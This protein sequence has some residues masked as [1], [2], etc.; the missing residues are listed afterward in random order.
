M[1]IYFLIFTQF[2]IHQSQSRHFYFSFFTVFIPRFF[3]YRTL[4]YL[5]KIKSIIQKKTILH[6]T[7]RKIARNS[8]TYYY[9][10]NKFHTRCK[11]CQQ[12]QS[13]TDIS[14]VTCMICHFQNYSSWNFRTTTNDHTSIPLYIK[15]KDL[16]ARKREPSQGI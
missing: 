5:L 7:I 3:Y 11:L 12:S 4:F 9:L 2:V 6:F 1:I 8:F 16:H 13:P 14:K 10:I 15:S